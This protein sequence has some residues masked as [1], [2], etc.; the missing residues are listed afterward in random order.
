MTDRYLKCSA[1][2]KR[3]L[4]RRFN[5]ELDRRAAVGDEEDQ[6]GY[7]SLELAE[8]E[9]QSKD[10]LQ[11]VAETVL[12]KYTVLYTERVSRGAQFRTKDEELDWMREMGFMPGR[13]AQQYLK[14]QRFTEKE[15]QYI[16]EKLAG[17]TVAE[18]KALGM[19]EL[20]DIA[21]ETSDHQNLTKT[22]EP[23]SEVGEYLREAQR[24]TA[25]AITMIDQALGKHE[26]EGVALLVSGIDSLALKQ[27]DD[28]AKKVLKE[29]FATYGKVTE[30]TVY[31]PSV[32]RTTSTTPEKT[33]AYAIIKLK[34]R[35]EAQ[36]RFPAH[37]WSLFSPS[38]GSFLV[39]SGAGSG[40]QLGRSCEARA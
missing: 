24:F 8:D 33:P 39:Q 26:R 31:H 32:R 14:Q 38:V 21:S 37:F 1:H 5:R 17:S 29:I 9:L 20:R 35:G 19:D 27:G 22:D 23:L 16:E 28:A 6:A 40:V 4:N 3:R 2:T 25:K 7:Q 10:E 11:F 13:Q 18:V 30:A 12:M 34:E 36:V 15:A